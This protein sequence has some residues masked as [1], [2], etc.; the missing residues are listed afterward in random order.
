MP[1][2]KNLCRSVDSIEYYRFMPKPKAQCEENMIIGSFQDVQA[3]V[4]KLK[5]YESQLKLKNIVCFLVLNGFKCDGKDVFIC[6][7]QITEL[8]EAF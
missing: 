2:L 7:H 8:L 6:A 3:L 5:R 4:K 1:W